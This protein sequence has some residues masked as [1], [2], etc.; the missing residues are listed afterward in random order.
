[1]RTPFSRRWD[2]L[3]RQCGACCYEKAYVKG[4]LYVYHDRPCVYLNE[5]NGRC[6]VYHERFRRME[7]CN[8]MTIFHAMFSGWLPASCGYV[9]W[10]MR[11]HIRFSRAKLD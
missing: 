1:M 2:S 5:E 10:A 3:C 8:K 11:H 4:I 7:G 9:E 6:K